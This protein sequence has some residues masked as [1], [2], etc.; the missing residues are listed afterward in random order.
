MKKIFLSLIFLSSVMLIQ[1]DLSGGEGDYCALSDECESPL[2][3]GFWGGNCMCPGSSYFV[4]GNP[5]CACHNG[6]WTGNGCSDSI[7]G[8]K[9]K[10]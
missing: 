8:L 9:V 3:C 6:S 7:A 1:T 5:P 2:V 10:K 4:G